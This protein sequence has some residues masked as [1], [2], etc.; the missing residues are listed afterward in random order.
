MGMPGRRWEKGFTLIETM[1][2]IVVVGI[3]LVSVALWERDVSTL[4]RVLHVAFVAQ[5]EARLTLKQLSAELRS[6][7]PSSTGA[8]PIDTAQS[9]TLIFYSDTDDDGLKER[10]RYVLSGQELRRGSVKPSGSPLG[11]DVSQE[12]VKTVA[13]DVLSGTPVFQYYDTS[14]DGTTAP[15][16]QPVDPTLVRLVKVTIV[17]DPTAVGAPAPLTL[18][19]Q[20]SVR[21][22][23]EN[24]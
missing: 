11:Y 22:L 6:A 23:K 14:Y 3:L 1:V 7:S 16:P 4:N 8:F 12:T 15:L 18:T 10:I 19:T 5:D 21:N 20:V 2:A 9:A 13:H 17:L 24:L